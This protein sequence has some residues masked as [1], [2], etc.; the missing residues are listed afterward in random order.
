VLITP[1]IVERWTHCDICYLSI[2]VIESPFG[3]SL[4]QQ[5]PIAGEGLWFGNAIGADV[6]WRGVCSYGHAPG[7]RHCWCVAEPRSG[8]MTSN[9]STE[10]VIGSNAQ[11]GVLPTTAG[12]ER[13]Y[14]TS[15][16]PANSQHFAHDGQSLAK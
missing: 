10:A 2:A 4:R 1:S 14:S 8:G 16:S 5:F 3:F 13:L 11:T 7:K 9:S 15:K 12:H 6:A